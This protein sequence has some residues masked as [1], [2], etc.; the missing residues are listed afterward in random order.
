MQICVSRFQQWRG[1]LFFRSHNETLSVVGMR[2]RNED[3]FTMNR[4]T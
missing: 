4:A 1:Q 2:V 3:P